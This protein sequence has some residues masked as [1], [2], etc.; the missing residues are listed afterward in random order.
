M[1][2]LAVARRHEDTLTLAAGETPLVSVIVPVY[3]AEGFVGQTVESALRQTYRN[4]E[5]II[6]DDGSTDRTHEVIQSFAATDSRIRVILQQ[7][8]GVARARNRG[9]AEARGEFIAPLDADDLWDPVKI[10]CQVRRMQDAGDQTG[11]T[12]CW[13]V[14]IDER[15]VLLDRSPR[16]EFEGNTLE[17]L[18]KV[19]FTGN[20][21]VP[22]YRRDCLNSVGGYDENLE[23]QGARGCEDWDVALK[24]AGRFQVAVVPQLLVGYR[25][26]PDSMS[27][28]CEV[29]WKSQQLLIAGLREREPEMNPQ[30]LR[31]SNDQF[32]LY[33]AGVLFRSGEYFRAFGW[34][35]RAWRSG[36]LFQV[37]PYVIVILAKRLRSGGH[38]QPQIMLPG[39]SL[40]SG[41]PQPLIP[42]DR[43]YNAQSQG[44]RP[45]EALAAW[46]RSPAWQSAALIL[47]FLF[48]AALHLDNDGLWFQGDS[49]RHA[50]NGLFW[51]DVLA[52]KPAHLADFALRYYAR[53]PTIN[54]IAYPPLFY[55]LE[56]LAFRVFGPSTY[57]AK[58]LILAMAMMAGFYTMAWARRWLGSRAGWVGAFL[59]LVPG[60]V[61]W[62]NAVMLNV[63]GVA[64]GLACLYHWR[65][66]LESG[67]Q[68]QLLISAGFGAAAV[69]TYY[70]AGIAI[71]IC[72]GWALLFQR[73]NLTSRRARYGL[74]ATVVC[75]AV[76][77]AGAAAVAPVLVAR[78]LPVISKFRDFNTWIFYPASL[79]T[80]V[81]PWLLALGL[82]GLAL[83]LRDTIW[84]KEAKFIAAWIA[85]AIVVF[86][87]LPATDARY[88]L[89]VAP[90]FVLA[91]AIGA[92]SLLRPLSVISPLWQAGILLAGLTVAGWQASRLQI[93]KDAGFRTVASYLS[94][95]APNDAVLY[96]GYHDGLFGFYFRAL[97]PQ[98]QRRL[99]LGQ[100]LFYHYG[101]VGTFHWVAT[102]NATST[103]DVV[104]ILRSR[105]GCSWVAIEVGSR[106]EEAEGQRLLR[107]AVSGPP[108]TRVNSF[109]LIASNAERIDL[110]RLDGE[111]RPV[112][113][114]DLQFTSYTNRTFNGVAPITR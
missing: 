9:L 39:M 30:A 53:Y 35:L 100:Q 33:I 4:L 92:A 36:L 101:P 7:N 62:S 88:I 60:I 46:L 38:Q 85:T 113:T 51:W 44:S 10:E 13:W 48:I 104:D 90:A 65:R 32:A 72:L 31:Q 93:P 76:L 82:I 98:Y 22:L 23:R 78:H 89:I 8:S 15:G 68:R 45:R 94:E 97:D 108:F 95:H 96:D 42:Y 87:F 66:S 18:L 114:I 80:L 64:L 74:L 27:S 70:P 16:W 24:V 20:A 26:L 49:P 110:Y 61:L 86:L 59:A 41:I 40:G 58:G 77:G 75:V 73:G 57:V 84:R 55:I 17:M 109:P 67:G 71:A 29:M 1:A 107:K 50:A 52:A 103:Q 5:I 25:R 11:M 106:S 19:N 14:W 99:V 34:A 2:G 69:L 47:S 102:M 3:N 112:S 43:I 54:P 91:A 12:Y 105:S 63:P 28:Q 37:L 56:G 83:G 81:G 6:V 111:I 79:R 21:S